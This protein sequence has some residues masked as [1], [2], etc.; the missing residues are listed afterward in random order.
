MKRPVSLLLAALL[1]LAM[2][3]GSG[4]WFSQT[5]TKLQG[6]EKTT[7]E[8]IE[9]VPKWPERQNADRDVLYYPKIQYCDQQ[10]QT[11]MFQSR[12]GSES[13]H[14]MVGQ[15]VGIR[16]NRDHPS[17]HVIDSFS[18]LWLGPTL[19]LAAGLTLLIALAAA[20]KKDRL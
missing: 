14:G 3:V 10:G 11:H 19:L 20:V 13:P 16:F 18:R 7:G 8:I 4:L 2:I 6:Y 9:L 12:V 15:K 17:E 1:P 5:A